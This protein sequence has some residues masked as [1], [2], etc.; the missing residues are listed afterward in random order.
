MQYYNQ[1]GSNVYL[2]SLDATK[3]FDR[4][5]FYKLFTILYNRGLPPMFVNTLIDWYGKLSAQVR[6]KDK[7]SAV[8]G[9]SSSVW[10][11]GILSLV[12]FNI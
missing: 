5:N 10:Q 8:F 9:V 12:L 4:V 6:W 11:G 1:R 3:A 7:F 2:A